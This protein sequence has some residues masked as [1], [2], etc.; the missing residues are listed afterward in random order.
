VQIA[1]LVESN[2]Q[3]NRIQV[4]QATADQLINGG[5]RLWL[6]A[7]EDLIEEKGKGM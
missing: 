7:R 4:S 2:G 6:S 3:Q 1:S 5:K